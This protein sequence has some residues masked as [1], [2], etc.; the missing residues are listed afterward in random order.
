MIIIVV[1]FEKWKMYKHGAW[2]Y[3]LKIYTQGL[4][5]KVE[6]LSQHR[7]FIGNTIIYQ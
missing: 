6:Y 5:E 3:R 2:S 7:Y 1:C 4:I